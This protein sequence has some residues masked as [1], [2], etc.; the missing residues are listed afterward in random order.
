MHWII[1]LAIWAILMIIALFGLRLWN[2]LTLVGGLGMMILAAALADYPYLQ[3]DSAYDNATATW[4][5]L[6]MI[7]PLYPTSVILIGLIGGLLMLIS[8][9]SASRS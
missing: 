1:F 2:L 9:L 6:E 3:I 8:V 7:I 5:T 4:S